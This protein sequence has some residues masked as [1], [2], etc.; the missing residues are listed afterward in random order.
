MAAYPD[1]LDLHV[2]PP[3]PSNVDLFYGFLY[4]SVSKGRFQHDDIP[5]RNS[6]WQET[7]YFPL[8]RTAPAG[9][10]NFKVCNNHND[11]D[12]PRPY[13]IYIYEGERRITSRS[14]TVANQLC[15]S[16]F[17]YTFAP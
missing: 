14:G 4:D 10:Y 1:D 5:D 11:P 8:E 13:S 9:V 3:S 15:T 2:F 12:P 7:V 17:T 16:N 6:T